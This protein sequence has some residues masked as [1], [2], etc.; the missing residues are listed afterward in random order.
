MFFLDHAGMFSL[1]TI[2]PFEITDLKAFTCQPNFLSVMAY[3]YRNVLLGTR[4]E[5]FN[6]MIITSSP[7]D[8]VP[9]KMEIH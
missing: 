3:S 9:L 6:L 7:T 4:L 5:S 1:L 2:F 8:Q